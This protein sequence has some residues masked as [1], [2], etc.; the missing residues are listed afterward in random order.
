MKIIQNALTLTVGTVPELPEVACLVCK[1]I[2]FSA[3]TSL[4]CGPALSGLQKL[5]HI[6]IPERSRLPED[7]LF[8]DVNHV[9]NL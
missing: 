6:Q 7:Y 1:S 4:A 2:G 8:N 5:F 3:E 9:I